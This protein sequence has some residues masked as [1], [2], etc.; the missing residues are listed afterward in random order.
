M[1]IP[2]SPTFD[3]DGIDVSFDFQRDESV[4]NFFERKPGLSI[5]GSANLSVSY[6]VDD[7]FGGI[8][9]VS[10]G[11]VYSI[12]NDDTFRNYRFYYLPATGEGVLSVDG[13]V[14]WSNDGPD[15]YVL[16]WSTSGN[17][18]VGNQMDGSDADKSCLDNLIVA[19]VFGS[20]LPI[21]L[22]SFNALLSN[23]VD[24][25]NTC[26]W[27]T[28]SEQDNDY[29]IVERS[30]NGIDWDEIGK[31]DGAGNSSQ[32]LEYEFLDSKPL[33]GLSYYRLTQYDFNGTNTNSE[34]RSVLNNN[35]N[36]TFVL[37]PNPASSQIFISGF[38]KQQ[39]VNIKMYNS[40]GQII[41]EANY[42]KAE[43]DNLLKLNIDSLKPGVYAVQLNGQTQRLVIN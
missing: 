38:D 2:G 8:T 21:E 5:R 16:D 9:T 19:S 34:I 3:V 41:L 17:V 7:G 12:P 6:R 20:P 43:L 26:T 31:V 35:T 29:F 1:I 28:L 13:V 4:A 27:I 40:L 18:E 14:V 33:P 22:I 11:S 37:Y 32:R 42:S 10:S 23:S 30:V 25:I 39:P 36:A 15:G 24:P